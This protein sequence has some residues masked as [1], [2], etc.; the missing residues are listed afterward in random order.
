V[1]LKTIG[2]IGPIAGSIV[3]PIW[4]KHLVWMSWRGEA[5]T[6]AFVMRKIHTCFKGD[7]SYGEE[8]DSQLTVRQ[9]LVSHV[10]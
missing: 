1:L 9:V 7:V 5:H 2:T 4:D 8:L 10:P 3:K 6:L